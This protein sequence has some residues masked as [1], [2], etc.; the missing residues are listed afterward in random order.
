MTTDPKADLLTRKTDVEHV[1]W[2]A[3]HE[4]RNHHYLAEAVPTYI[5]GLVCSDTAAFLCEDI[6][7]MEDTV[8]Y[9]P[10]IEDWASFRWRF[11]PENR[12]WQM[13]REMARQAA[14]RGAGRYLVALPDFQVA[15]DIVSLLRA[16]ER[17]CLDLIE[18]PEDVKRATRF[19]IDVYTTCYG[20]IRA[21]LGPPSAWV[22]DWMG[23]FARGT[24]DIVQCDF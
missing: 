10:V 20:E 13:T 15:I 18:R 2:R 11:D 17:L 19:I 7:I 16:P 1:L 14:A 8:W 5:P 12:W 6:T 3:E 22:G 21:I 24:H 9:H 4:F 23:L